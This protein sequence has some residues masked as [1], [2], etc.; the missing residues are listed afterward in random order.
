LYADSHR[1]GLLVLGGE[2]PLSDVL[3]GGPSVL[4]RHRPMLLLDFSDVPPARR[5]AAWEACAQACRERNYTWHDGLLLPCS[6]R[7]DRDAAVTAIGHATGVGLPTEWNDMC[8]LPP[9]IADMLT[10][11]DVDIA[12]LAW[13]GALI[14]VKR[15]PTPDGGRIRF[16]DTLLSHGMYRTE[17][18]GQ[19]ACWRWTGPGPRAS[20]L[21]PV[22]GPG[23]WRLHLEVVNWGSAKPRSTLRALVGGDFLTVER[24]GEDF[25]SFAPLA[26]PPFWSGGSL[27]VDLTTPRPRRASAHDARCLGVSLAGASLSRI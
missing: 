6:T 21:V 25:V 7:A 14:G 13:A 1:P 3:M 23:P 8:P 18:G 11:E 17:V 2:R 19:G 26:P 4:S 9:N 10:P 24:S 22:P 27:R 5:A 15:L 20:F 12:R 16:D